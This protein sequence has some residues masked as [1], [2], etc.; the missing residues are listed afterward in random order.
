M[1][2]LSAKVACSLDRRLLARVERLRA[3]TGE[4]RSAV[5]GRALALLTTEEARAAAVRRYVEAY[6]EMPESSEE[7]TAAASTALQALASL[8]REER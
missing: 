5:I 1:A 8:A 7:V 2:R 4:S 6:R 3:R